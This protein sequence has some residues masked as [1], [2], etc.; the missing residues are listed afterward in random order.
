MDLFLCA[1]V[2]KCSNIRIYNNAIMFIRIKATAAS[3][4]T[5][6]MTNNRLTYT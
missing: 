2:N 5:D 1:I 6:M 3:V 4:I